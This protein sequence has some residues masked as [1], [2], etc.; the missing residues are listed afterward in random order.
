MPRNRSRRRT[1]WIATLAFVALGM[2]KAAFGVA[3]PSVSVELAVPIGSLGLLIAVFVGCYLLSTATSGAMA[4]AIGVGRLLTVT[5]WVAAAGLAGYALAPSMGG[6]LAAAAVLGLAS[7][8]IDAGI[9]THIALRHGARAMGALHAGFGIGAT[10]GP[11]AMTGLLTAEHGWRWGMWM[12]FAVQ[13][14]VAVGFLPN[15]KMWTSSSPPPG[16]RRQPLSAAAG[17]A[18]AVFALYAAVEIGVGQWTFTLLTEGREMSDTVAGLAVTGLYGGLTGARLLLG[19]VGHRGT[20][21]R[22][23]TT[24]AAVALAGVIALWWAPTGSVAIAATLVTGFALGPIFPLQI[25]LTP[26]RVGAAGTASVVGY[27]MAAASL[28]AIAIP[29]AIGLLVVRFEVGVIA[30]A[31]AAT[32]GMLVLA[33]L[34][35][36]RASR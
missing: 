31:L 13:A 4:A 28:G 20:P 29:G 26:Q 22:L 2:P 23:S 30:P 1:L 15:E 21:Q 9:N 16:H 19:A 34:A 12:L 10:L 14:A 6:L 25:L 7:G 32:A 33:D 17:W 3:W 36:R 8:Y 27:Q 24:G 11:L 5:S 35:L 18:L